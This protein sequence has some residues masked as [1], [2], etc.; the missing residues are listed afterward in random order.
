MSK[1]D[2]KKNNTKT[3]K[4]EVDMEL[5]III[6]GKSEVGKTCLIHKYF[7]T[8]FL[9]NTITTI[10][11]DYKTKHFLFDDKKV[12]INYLD[13]AG[14]ERFKTIT[15]NYLRNADGILLV[16]AV[17]SRESFKLL[18]EWLKEINKTRGET[19]IIVLANK[20]DLKEKELSQEDANEFSTKHGHKV[21]EV[22]ARTGKGVDEAFNDIASI[23][24]HKVLENIRAG[25]SNKR[26][27]LKF[28]TKKEKKEQNCCKE[29]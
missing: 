20:I 1:Q 23:T 26:I 7:G 18:D 4:E 11:I 28:N 15:T 13:T 19:P 25:K 6:L 8:E 21:Y 14:Q 3:K 17:D 10:G 29:H 5:K 9:E 2:K 24:Y 27:S 16:Y 22:S 12:K